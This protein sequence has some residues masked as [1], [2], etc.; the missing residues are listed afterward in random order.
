MARIA[1]FPVFSQHNRELD[2]TRPVRS[3]KLREDSHLRLPTGSSWTLPQDPCV[4]S[5]SPAGRAAEVRLAKLN[6]GIGAEETQLV[7]LL[8][9]PIVG[10]RKKAQR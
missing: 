3:K 6:P 9:G 2:G 4:I 8:S 7:L 10:G 5:L 1:K